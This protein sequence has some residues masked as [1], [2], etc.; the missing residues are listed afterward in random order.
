MKWKHSAISWAEQGLSSAINLSGI[1]T[2]SAS[3][4]NELKVRALLLTLCVRHSCNH[5][6]TFCK[7]CLHLAC[8]VL[9]YMESTAPTG[10]QTHSLMAAPSPGCAHQEQRGPPVLQLPL[11]GRLPGAK[12]FKM[13]FLVI[14]KKRFFS[15]ATE[16]VK[17][18][19]QRSFHTTAQLFK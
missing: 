16:Y 10:C 8:A 19:K 1:H 3:P 13:C 6:L 2:F 9:V 7:C 18:Q 4:R 15:I 5:P 12:G 11:Q 14:F 17:K